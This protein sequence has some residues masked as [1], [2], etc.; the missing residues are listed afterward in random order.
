MNS[1]ETLA[2]GG[3]K[4][5]KHNE[6][7]SAAVLAAAGTCFVGGRLPAVTPA[8]PCRGRCLGVESQRPWMEVAPRVAAQGG[9]DRERSASVGRSE[10]LITVWNPC[11]NGTS[12]SSSRN[13]EEEEA[14]ALTG[15]V[16]I[17]IGRSSELTR[18]TP[19][20]LSRPHALRTETQ[21]VAALIRRD[22]VRAES[23]VTLPFLHR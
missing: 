6:A 5:R 11:R 12:G 19:C 14:A 23:A 21:R 4:E 7:D 1:N 18:F 8:S 10:E 20:P 9:Y 3:R 2:A 16:M 17:L 22:N 15:S 13:E